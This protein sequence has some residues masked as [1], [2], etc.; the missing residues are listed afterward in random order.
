MLHS[1]DI[2][3]DGGAPR[4][5]LTIDAH[6]NLYGTSE[7][8]ANNAQTGNGVVYKISPPAAGNTKWTETV[9]YIFQ[10][11]TEGGSPGF[12]TVTFDKSGDLYGTTEVGGRDNGGTTVGGTLWRLSPPTKGSGS[13]TQ[14]TLND[15]TGEPDPARPE[16]GVIFLGNGDL[17]GTSFYGGA[18]N[19]GTVYSYTP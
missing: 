14:T 3:F 5:G 17:V 18:D 1:F 13:W 7:H 9:L 15:F 10:T 16:G 6:G 11:I 19:F 12:S 2:N 4:M 8:M